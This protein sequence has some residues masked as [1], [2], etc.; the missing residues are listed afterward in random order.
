MTVARMLD[1]LDE[2]VELLRRRFGQRH[3]ILLGHSWGTVLG[4]MYAHRHPDKVAAYV[5]TGQIA[6]KRAG[7]RHSYQFALEQARARGDA[8]ATA[9]LQ[10]ID[11]GHF[12]VDGVFAL[13]RWIER[14]GGTFHADLSTGK[15][16]WAALSTDEA[17]LIDLV[18][19][20][21]GNRFSHRCL[22]DEFLATDLTRLR[23][24]DVP[25]FFLLGRYDQVT[26]STLAQSYFDSINAPAKQLVW[27]EGSAHNPP[28]EE[29]VL[30]SRVLVERVRPLVRKQG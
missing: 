17:N 28:F 14:F 6:D 21:R 16:L 18:Q 25:V 1:D 4:T 20:G 12:S 27:F 23:N 22:L 26:P 8:K 24:F 30:F 2:L 19:F 3:M 29:P 10:A 13:G 9:S 7:D 11:V 5:G 15:L